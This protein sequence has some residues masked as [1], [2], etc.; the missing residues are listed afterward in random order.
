MSRRRLFQAGRAPAG[1]GAAALA[2]LVDLLTLLVVAL[3]RG[4]SADPPVVVELGFSLPISRQER[5]ASPPAVTV[6][7]GPRGL[8]VDGW[9]L[10]P[11][12]AAHGGA[13]RVEAL[14]GALLRGEKGRL[15]L[16]VDAAAPYAD[17][18]RLLFTAR[19][20]GFAEVELVAT[21]ASSL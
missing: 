2:P 12:E 19:E 15:R 4:Q 10:G 21:R 1:L 8:Y 3:L 16:R 7:L 18:D 17:V 20:A 6:D 13:G 14:Y 5:A 11:A 9:R